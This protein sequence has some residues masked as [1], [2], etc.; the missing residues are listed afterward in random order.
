MSGK[1]LSPES[2]GVAAAITAVGVA[3]EGATL[4]ND[5]V[6]YLHRDLT[7]ESLEIPSWLQAVMHASIEPYTN[8][9]GWAA[10]HEVHHR[11]ADADLFSFVQIADYLDYRNEN[12]NK[13]KDH[14]PLPEKFGNLDRAAVD[15]DLATVYEIGVSGRELVEGKY[16]PKED[17]TP[18]E[19]EAVL[20]TK[21]LRYLYEDIRG[22]KTYP[23]PG[24]V[25]H[26]EDVRYLLRDPHSPAL[27]PNTVRGVY[28][29]NVPLY[30]ATESAF[31]N[32]DQL[33]ERLARTPWQEKMHKHRKLLLG[34]E[35]GAHVVGGAGIGYMLGQRKPSQMIRNGLV[36]GAIMSGGAYALVKGGQTVNAIGH[37]GIDPIR[38]LRTNELIPNPDGSYT[39]NANRLLGYWTGDEAGWQG[40][41]HAR[42]W[43]IAFA[44]RWRD[45]PF[46]KAVEFIARHHI[47]L[48][49]RDGFGDDTRPDVVHPAVQ[50]IES[51]RVKS[52]QRGSIALRAA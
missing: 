45:A 6:L 37:G 50:R 35:I 47:L 42:P 19:A 36:G 27:H 22:K 44:E 30:S 29:D 33:P 11:V 23:G 48:D 1:V 16:E 49:E 5:T 21:S 8:P 15:L 3:I 17:Y 38:A 40:N 13:L 9:N 10:T 52:M 46:G 31:N 39:T 12:P 4:L 18:E 14:P 28:E 41:H 26:L 51:E 34:L 20:D 24:E 7:H 2:L 32:N 43:D 25:W